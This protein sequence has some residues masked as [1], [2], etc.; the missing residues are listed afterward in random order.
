MLKSRVDIEPHNPDQRINLTDV[1][2]CVK[3]FSGITYPYLAP[4]ICP[5]PD[6]T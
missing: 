4:V 6:N 2:E 5:Q 3:A 1:L